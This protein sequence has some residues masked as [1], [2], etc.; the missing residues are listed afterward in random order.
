MNRMLLIAVPLFLFIS[1]AQAEEQND[2]LQQA[3][4]LDCLNISDSLVEKD[5]KIAIDNF[6]YEMT[7]ASALR[8][9]TGDDSIFADYYNALEQ[10]RFVAGLRYSDDMKKLKSSISSNEQREYIRQVRKQIESRQSDGVNAYYSKG[11]PNKKYAVQASLCEK[12]SLGAGQGQVLLESVRE[13]VSA[14][15]K[16]TRESSI[17]YFDVK[18]NTCNVSDLPITGNKYTEPKHWAGSRFV[19][20]DATFKNQDQEGRLPSE[21]SLIINHEGRELRYDSTEAIMQEGYGIYFKSVNP[22]ITMPTKIVY[23]IPDEV[24]GEVSW[25]PGRNSEG[26]RLW[27][28]FASPKTKS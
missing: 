20:I 3:S 12:K 16:I 5:K 6:V 17:G 23:R 1:H 22:L 10:R 8:Y 21:G 7:K 26:K 24:S 15:S 14:S 27:C 9:L 2:I 4:A 11:S 19:V 13:I 25:E 18:I 28:T